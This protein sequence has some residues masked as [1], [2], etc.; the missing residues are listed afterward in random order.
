MITGLV[1]AWKPRP[2]PPPKPPK[3]SQCNNGVV[4]VKRDNRWVETKCGNCDGHGVIE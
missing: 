1:M 4:K 3:C 2:K